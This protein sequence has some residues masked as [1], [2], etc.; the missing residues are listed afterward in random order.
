[1]FTFPRSVWEAGGPEI[2][3]ES[4]KCRGQ[5]VLKEG[6]RLHNKIINCSFV[7]SGLF[8]GGRG[9]AL[10]DVEGNGLRSQP[11]C[12]VLKLLLNISLTIESLS[13]REKG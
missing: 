8:L 1:M 3:R 5:L 7:L 2:Q 6:E 13:K 11:L 10:Y 9:G 12:I 4:G